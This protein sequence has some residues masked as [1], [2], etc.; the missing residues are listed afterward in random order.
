MQCG[1]GVL[2]ANTLHGVAD[3]QINLEKHFR[4]EPVGIRTD[5]GASTRA[6]R[7]ADG[8]FE[9]LCK[10]HHYAWRDERL[11]CLNALEFTSLFV[12]RPWGLLPDSHASIT[13]APR[14]LRGLPH[15]CVRR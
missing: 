6:Y 12:R 7:N 1:P 15:R 10:M 3:T 5:E 4:T 9:L 14:L 2:D 13:P 11:E 8:G